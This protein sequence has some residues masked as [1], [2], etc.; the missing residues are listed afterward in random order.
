MSQKLYRY[1][2]IWINFVFSEQSKPNVDI[3]S[4]LLSEKLNNRNRINWFN[5]PVSHLL[6]FLV[7]ELCFRGRVVTKKN[8]RYDTSENRI[9]QNVYSSFYL[10][11]FNPEDSVIW[12]KSDWALRSSH[13]RIVRYSN[14]IFYYVI[15]CV[16]V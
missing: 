7:Y 14:L 6:T 16:Y 4:N 1:A 15:H 2:G 3:S 11:S 5:C 13:W 9:S 12:K 8:I 10:Y